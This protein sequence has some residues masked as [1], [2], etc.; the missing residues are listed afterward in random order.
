MFDLVY[1]AAQ[2]VRSAEKNLDDFGRLLDYSWSLKKKIA[3]EI[4]NDRV[5]MFYNNEAQ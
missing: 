2:I 3:E 5:D 1:Q 4:S